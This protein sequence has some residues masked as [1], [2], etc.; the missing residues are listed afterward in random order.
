[1]KT[2]HI[3]ALAVTGLAAA[4]VVPTGAQA[5]TAHGGG[6]AVAGAAARP[7]TAENRTDPF[8]K[9]VVRSR[10]STTVG[11]LTASLAAT[12]EG[13]ETFYFD[14]TGSTDTASPI[15]NYSV[16]FGD[17]S[18]PQTS[19]SGTFTYKYAWA[20]TYTAT[21]TVTDAVGTTATATVTVTTP[22]SDYT[23]YGPTRIL[24]TRIGTGAPAAAVGPNGVV[25]LQVA[26]AGGA[27]DPIPAGVTAIAMN[28]TVTAPSSAGFITAYPDG[29][30]TPNASNINYGPGK[31]IPNL[32]VVQVGAD[33][34]V[35][36]KNSS[37][38]TVQLVADVVGYYSQT[39]ASQYVSISPFRLLD[40][41]NGTGTGVVRQVGANSSITVQVAGADAA[42]VPNTGVTAI[43]ANITVTK[44]H[45]NGFV[46]AYPSGDSLPNASN[47]N[48]GSGET[49]ANMAT[50]PVGSNGEIVIH[51][52]S[53]GGVDVVIDVSGY[54]TDLVDAGGSQP[55]NSYIPNAPVR[56]LDTRT[57]GFG[58]LKS[59][60]YYYELGGWA[61]GS[62]VTSVVLNTTITNPKAN[63][64]LT[65]YPV[66]TRTF[67]DVPNSSNINFAPGQTVANLAFVP[68]G[69]TEYGDGTSDGY[70]YYWF[71]AYNASSN[72]TDLVLDQEGLFLDD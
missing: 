16:D 70:E 33:G 25:K 54:F 67:S 27:S 5:A 43:A 49:V 20:G 15:V 18:A 24:D 52:S 36:L 63:G 50:I 4:I 57:W 48:Y 38:G 53:N 51:N 26:G 72:T 68:L 9:N 62:D 37:A 40:T 39:K 17:G 64:F 22:G 35:D 19:S 30:A 2:R 29:V 10:P 34:I 44:P 55:T 1:M 61:V 45:T 56:G 59:Y 60:W 11:G 8:Q 21:V 3:A 28:V 32:V 23:P 71:G 6:H 41:R 58:P 42:L 47:V 31:T 13:A 69:T 14:A 65:L 46:T 66:N 7:T 12:T